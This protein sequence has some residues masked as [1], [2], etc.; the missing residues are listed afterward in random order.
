MKNLH[1]KHDFSI[2]KYEISMNAAYVF[3]MRDELQKKQCGSIT[4][5]IFVL[6]IGALMNVHGLAVHGMLA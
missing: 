2:T 4:Y 5:P 1:I 3:A 6:A